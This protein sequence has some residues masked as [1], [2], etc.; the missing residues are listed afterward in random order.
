M[1]RAQS[2]L[3]MQRSIAAVRLRRLR[4]I[5]AQKIREFRAHH[6]PS[7][8][9]TLQQVFFG[10]VLLL[11]RSS[12]LQVPLARRAKGWEN[13]RSQLLPLAP[14]KGIDTDVVL[15]DEALTLEKQ[16]TLL[17]HQAAIDETPVDRSGTRPFIQ[18]RSSIV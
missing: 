18:L 10:A 6:M 9:H 3:P 14:A 15:G 8:K 13:L 1:K 17:A 11:T 16:F 4:R 5:E 7:V 12:F 2:L